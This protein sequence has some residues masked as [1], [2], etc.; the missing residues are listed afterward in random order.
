M[1]RS[2]TPRW[3][4]RSTRSTARCASIP[5]A[6]SSSASRERPA[7]SMRPSSTAPAAAWP[8]PWPSLHD[9]GDDERPAGLAGGPGGRLAG[10]RRPRGGTWAR[11]ILFD[12]NGTVQ[13]RPTWSRGP[14][15]RW[16]SRAT[17]ARDYRRRR[18]LRGGRPGPIVGAGCG[19]RVLRRRLVSSAPRAVPV[20]GTRKRRD[21]PVGARDLR[22]SRLLRRRRREGDRLG[23]RRSQGRP[24]LATRT[25]VCPTTIDATEL[26][27]TSELERRR[28][29]TGELKPR[30]GAGRAIEVDGSSGGVDAQPAWLAA[31]PTWTLFGEASIEGLDR[32]LPVALAPG[33]QDLPTSGW[34]TVRGHFDDPAASTCR[35]TYP[36]TGA[37][38]PRRPT[39]RRG[40]AKSGSS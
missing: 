22:R 38:R 24:V 32:G 6:G 18:D 36:R 31:E 15:K 12:A 5:A 29:A 4:R 1:R 27:Y 25:P 14:A 28:C 19:H 34:L 26:A 40:V 20:S 10:D 7:R 39:R 8:N 30:A 2:K 13:R 23:R 16:P 17:R 37:L 9:D 35:V 33:L 21:H 11:R 3:A